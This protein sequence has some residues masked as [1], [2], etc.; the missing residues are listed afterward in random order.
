MPRKKSKLG[1]AL[2]WMVRKMGL[3][4][5]VHEYKKAKGEDPGPLDPEA[6]SDKVI[7]AMRALAR[8]LLSFRERYG[9]FPNGLRDVTRRRM[10]EAREALLREDGEA[11][12]EDET[13]PVPADA[14]LVPTKRHDYVYLPPADGADDEMILLYEPVERYDGEG[15]NVTLISGKVLW[16]NKA[17]FQKRLQQTLEF[18]ER[19]RKEKMKWHEDD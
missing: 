14:A 16:L 2:S 8:R 18:N 4:E 1:S 15:T 9:N 7:S 13:P 12:A 10:A 19:A 5:A 17:E 11:E 6:D 3:P